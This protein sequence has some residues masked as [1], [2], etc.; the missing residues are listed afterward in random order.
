MNEGWVTFSSSFSN[1][2]CV[3]WRSH[4]SK[5]CDRREFFK[6]EICLESAKSNNAL[7]RQC[8]MKIMDSRPH[9]LL[10]IMPSKLWT[11]RV[12]KFWKSSRD[13]LIEQSFFSWENGSI[14]F[15]MMFACKGYASSLW[16]LKS[17][18]HRSYPRIV[19]SK[20]CFKVF[21]KIASWLKMNFLSWW[22]SVSLELMTR[23]PPK[24]T[25]HCCQAIMSSFFI[26]L[27]VKHV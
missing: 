19:C 4:L 21:Q 23:R 5:V 15:V 9:E 14:Q 17:C 3:D 6:K 26:R 8:L 2:A 18:L 10:V 16:F 7:W 20:V 13:I 27:P 24:E 12:K 22:A 25:S 1:I 11:F